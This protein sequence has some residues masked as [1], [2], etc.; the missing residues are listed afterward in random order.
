MQRLLGITRNRTPKQALLRL[1]DQ[2]RDRHG[3]FPAVLAR[4]RML[5][6][7]TFGEF[8]QLG[9]RVTPHALDEVTKQ[10]RKRDER[11]QIGEE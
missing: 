9:W 8:Q 2:L 11:Y 4:F 7:Q 10:Y 1:T 6:V 5:G 3:A